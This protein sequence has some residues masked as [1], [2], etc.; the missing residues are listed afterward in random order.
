MDY[1]F[2][3]ETQSNDII[4]EFFSV[5][6][7][8]DG[9]Y[10][11]NSYREVSFEIIFDEDNDVRIYEYIIKCRKLYN[12]MYR[13]ITSYSEHEGGISLGYDISKFKPHSPLITL[14]DGDEWDCELYEYK[15]KHNT[16]ERSYNRQV[17]S[18]NNFEIVE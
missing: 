1:N 17:N 10:Y 8:R 16:Q 18:F 13:I 9:V 11:D 3:T 7:L 4:N 12:L 2:Y 14:S 6:T 5:I 15:P